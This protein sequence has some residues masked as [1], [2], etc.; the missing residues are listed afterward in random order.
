MTA[1]EENP[2]IEFPAILG[3][4][5]F[6]ERIRLLK[7]A[8]AEKHHFAVV[9]SKYKTIL[10]AVFLI[11]AA[12]LTLKYIA[13]YV[14]NTPH[15][16]DT[17]YPPPI[18]PALVLAVGTAAFFAALFIPSFMRC[19]VMLPLFAVGL[20]ISGFGLINQVNEYYAAINRMV[21]C[22]RCITTW[23]FVVLFMLFLGALPLIFAS[24]GTRPIFPG[25]RTA[26]LMSF[27]FGLA[28]VILS[29]IHF[30]SYEDLRNL[31][32]IPLDI[33]ID[34]VQYKPEI[35]SISF[36]FIGLI[37]V[38]MFSIIFFFVKRR[39]RVTEL[40]FIYKNGCVVTSAAFLSYS[41]LIFLKLFVYS[42]PW[43]S[44]SDFSTFYAFL[45]FYSC[46]MLTVLSPV[47]LAIAGL[48][49]FFKQLAFRSWAKKVDIEIYRLGQELAAYSEH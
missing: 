11:V 1:S 35:T 36:F 13:S 46:Y 6:E 9:L 2:Q 5:D 41:L 29:C 26:R 24:A 34:D 39:Q 20:I 3:P 15:N 14:Q 12:S 4:A 10:A 40:A 23:N 18:Y 33:G 47:L 44:S 32:I 31:S 22:C 38:G 42:Y 8:R 48:S 16:C 21:S 28:V 49:D 30:S 43:N 25:N 27:I 17:S 19:L 45:Y 37:I 7:A